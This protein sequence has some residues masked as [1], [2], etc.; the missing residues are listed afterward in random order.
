MPLWTCFSTDALGS[1]L[2]ITTELLLPLIKCCKNEET[3]V[4]LAELALSLVSRRHAN[5]I[6]AR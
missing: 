2:T 1:T 3:L 4:V 5:E 6:V